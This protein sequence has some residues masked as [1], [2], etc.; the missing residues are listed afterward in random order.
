MS[1]LL[2]QML[3]ESARRA[4]DAVAVVDGDRVITYQELDE[5]ANQLARTL[6]VAGASRGDRIGLYLDKSIES[7]V[8]LYAVLKAGCAYVPLD[9]DGP[10]A[11]LGAILADCAVT[12]LVTE[13]RLGARWPELKRTGAP[14]TTLIVIDA[15]TPP[16]VE[17]MT[18][19]A[20]DVV[21]AQPTGP[22][23]ERST[24][25]DLAYILYTSGSTAS[26]KGVMLS[27]LNGATFV[28]WAV[29]TFGVH[30][31]DR[32]SSHAPLHFDLSIFDVFAAARAGAAVVLVRGRTMAFPAL[33]A[34]LIADKEISVW[35]S[36]PS[37]LTMLATRGGLTVGDL[38][39]LRVVLFAG[40]VF[41]IKHLRRLMALLPHARFCNLYGPTETN[42]C[43]WYD[44]PPLTEDRA[45]AVNELPI[46]GAIDGVEVLA[47]TDDGLEAAVGE[48]GELV[49]RG[50]TVM[51]GYWGDADRTAAAL[52]PHPIRPGLPHP[53]YRTGDLVVRLGD[54]QYRFLGRRDS[55]VKSRGYRIELGEVEKVIDQNADVIECA[56]VAVPDE[57]VTNV[58]HAYVV[59]RR[60]VTLPALIGFCAY[61]LPKHMIPVTFTFVGN[62]PRTST[63]KIDRRSLAERSVPVTKEPRWTP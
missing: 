11:R 16:L 8:G 50:P 18:A 57:L 53:V 54:G 5:R 25:F 40:E 51:Q 32:V 34:R 61:R 10:P 19:I 52:V 9:S 31:G 12:C 23:P 13:S 43:T 22:P 33:L 36:V 56:V 1:A 24:C 55:Q 20:A 27:H 15:P 47:V 49:V 3:E 42:V 58:L 44:V 6:L 35:Y 37:A 62:L 21:R 26:P 48:A 14:L 60:E 2:H 29:R 63:G 17:G 59:T 38:P 30:A 4:P 46:G 28:E 7:F 45:E 41:P 39:S